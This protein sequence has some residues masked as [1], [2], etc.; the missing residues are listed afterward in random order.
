MT[1]MKKSTETKLVVW[2]F[3]VAVIG[4]LIAILAVPPEEWLKNINAWIG[5]VTSWFRA[6]W[7]STLSLGVVM[8]LAIARWFPRV[9]RRR[10]PGV[11][12]AAAAPEDSSER[13]R[14]LRKFRSHVENLLEAS[15][16]RAY[17][18]SLGVK[19]S[20]GMTQPR[21]QY[22]NP[23][24]QQVL[25]SVRDAYDKADGRLLLL[26][27]PG[28]GKSTMLL[29]LA[30][31][32]IEQA[33]VD[34]DA[35]VPFI[36]NLSSL[37]PALQKPERERGFLERWKSWR[38]RA[39]SEI[40]VKAWLTGEFATWSGLRRKVARTWVANNRIAFLLDGLDEVNDTRRLECAT[41]LNN[42]LL[43]TS[44]RF[45]VVVCSRTYEYL[46]IK[47][48]SE[49]R[50]HLAG[51]ATLQPL[52]DS[53]VLDFL[54]AANSEALKS[55][56]Q[57]DPELMLM[58]KSPL[59]LNFM[60]L[61]YS[62]KARDSIQIKGT[63]TERYDA[64]MEAYVNRMQQRTE[65]KLRGRV[66]DAPGEEVPAAEYRY[67][68]RRLF[69]HLGWIAI[70]MSIR[71]RTSVSPE[72]F[73]TF[74]WDAKE[75][76]MRRDERL[77]SGFA[78][79]SAASII[80]LVALCAIACLNPSYRRASTFIIGLMPILALSGLAVFSRA[81]WLVACL[82]AVTPVALA[83]FSYSVLSV[84]PS[85]GDHYVVLA[86]ILATVLTV[87]RVNELSP[88]YT[89]IEWQK[90][91]ITLV[92]LAL[93]YLPPAIPWWREQV[94]SHIPPAFT[95]IH[96]HGYS[97]SLLVDSI[98]VAAVL[99]LKPIIDESGSVLRWLIGL[100]VALLGFTLAVALLGLT[101]DAPAFQTP[102]IVA[103]AVS[104]A[105][106]VGAR[107]SFLYL[108][109][110]ALVA[111][112]GAIVFP[113]RGA[114]LGLVGILLPAT[115]LWWLISDLLKLGTPRAESNAVA[116]A[117]LRIMDSALL[118][119]V[120]WRVLT[121]LRRWP[122]RR[123]RFVSYCV[124]ALV[125]RPSS[126]YEFYHRRLR[127]YFALSRLRAQLKGAASDGRRALIESLG[128][129]G[130][131]AVETLYDLIQSEHDEL[132][133]IAAAALGRISSKDATAAIKHVSRHQ[134]AAVRRA[135]VA[136]LRNLEKHEALPIIEAALD[137]EDVSVCAAA[138]AA[139]QRVV[140]LSIF[141]SWMNLKYD[142]RQE[143]T[144]A[145]RSY[146][147]RVM[148]RHP[149]ELRT[150][151]LFLVESVF[152]RGQWV[153]DEA[154]R[155]CVELL[156][157]VNDRAKCICLLVL[158]D[159]G[160]PVSPSV[161]LPLL[162]LE[163][164]TSVPGLALCALARCARSESVPYLVWAMLD[165]KADVARAADF[166]FQEMRDRINSKLEVAPAGFDQLTE[167]TAAL[168]KR[169]AVRGVPRWKA[170]R[171]LREARKMIP[172]ELRG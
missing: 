85:L 108:V 158:A 129:Q 165:G 117:V 149:P 3:V 41:L 51:A 75:E 97:A 170:Q 125:L 42:T 164:H 54:Q 159:R 172:R 18:I 44:D 13:V 4:A 96:N 17:L 166:C 23:E 93:I 73:F 12:E 2:G 68:A 79:G 137:D 61:A 46:P 1:R 94:A 131:A 76:E 104:L 56:I 62:G 134:S 8:G 145:F 167:V 60:A 78:L 16:H 157:A 89:D 59:I 34:R 133:A 135:V 140:V 132:A 7:W 90:A 124:M 119:P 160:L 26:G 102:V 10:P 6:R 121:G 24:R 100:P 81:A 57:D 120:T 155:Y 146:V 107:T 31:Y 55:A 39:V 15:L 80:S 118:T 148:K 83:Q 163:P 111:V 98:V 72:R 52:T 20:Q 92:A 162:K 63:R 150:L 141:V 169:R 69:T 5:T 67:S 113:E 112:I 33:E 66:S 28:S 45:P 138:L 139:A 77:A 58:A 122:W 9:T 161:L 70:R 84:A 43:R 142:F 19:A 171:V 156:G 49:A 143:E 147:E 53:D 151:K 114:V 153:P 152:L 32:L 86:A 103:G 127:D 123:A 40:S 38:V 136:N 101:P 88:F 48:H 82:V 36:Q 87:A 106:I 25:H 35:P 11:A 27:D 105:A 115:L 144:V 47:D 30:L 109:L 74:I 50:L 154:H 168:E 110:P 99:I 91:W 37:F 65:L 95:L 71:M 14:Y 116:A 128:F 29:D 64:L 126:D 22:E 21:L 130:D